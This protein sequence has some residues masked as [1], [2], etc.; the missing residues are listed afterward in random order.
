MA[1]R[2][3]TQRHV[4]DGGFGGGK[5]V[6]QIHQRRA[7]VAEQA[8]IHVR[9][10]G[11]L[12]QR[13]SGLVCHDV[14]GI[15]Q[16]D[17]GAGE[18][19]Q[20]VL[21]DAQLARGGHDLVDLAG[22]GGNLRGHGLG[23]RGQR[24]KFRLGSV[25]GLS[26]AGKGGLKV[27]RR[28]DGRR[29]QGQHGR[30]HGGGQRAARGG[31]AL[32]DCV[33]LLA[34]ILQRL[35]RRRPGGLR[36]GKQLI[37]LFDLR[38]RRRHG[39]SGPI[40]RGFRVDDRVVCL[41]DFLRVVGLL[42]GFELLLCA[43]Q[44]RLVLREASA[45]QIELFGEQRL[46]GRKPRDAGIQLFDAHGGELEAALGQGDLLAEGGDGSA[47]L[48]DGLSRRVPI[49]LRQTQR[50][51]AAG[52]LRLRAPNGGAGV[53]EVDTR[54]AH[55]V[56]GALCALLE[57]RVLPGELFDLLH[58]GA[59]LGLERVQIGPRGDGGGVAVAQRLRKG[60][61]L[62]RGGGHLCPERLLC[63]SGV[64]EALGV[65]ALPGKALLQLVVG[66]GERAPV[67]R[68]GLL[69]KR[70]PPLERGQLHSQPFRTLLEA[71]HAR[72]GEA[73]LALRFSDLLLDR[74]DVAGKVVRLK[75]QGHHQVAEGFAHLLS[76]AN[77]IKRSGH[78][79]PLNFGL[80]LTINTGIL[81]PERS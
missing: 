67:L 44:S 50:L 18:I 78:E 54:R 5:L 76:P 42:R 62:L 61:H 65:V 16:V 9:D 13:G 8:L 52:D 75:R 38:S 34:E 64:G 40:Q 68:D 30:G 70:E 46:F 77:R 19:R 43:L 15:A 27:Q 12:R 72:G 79:L 36:G 7:Q 59:V 73:K 33:A 25:H 71:L 55:R 3:Q 51:V 66:G 2:C 21:V 56:G 37:R 60:A 28:L 74:A 58:G 26:H 11:E 10:V 47:A 49:R 57:G 48:V 14:R 24:V 6:A 41:T 80:N 20:I 4:H 31:Q 17:H 39:G 63:G 1:R 53:V 23:G 22:G 69:L 45:L 35:A 32:A 81:R 29:A